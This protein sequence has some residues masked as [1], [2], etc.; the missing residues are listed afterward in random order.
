MKTS[1]GLL[2][3]ALLGGSFSYCAK[4]QDASILTYHGDASSQG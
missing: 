4:A 1:I 2:A 3:A